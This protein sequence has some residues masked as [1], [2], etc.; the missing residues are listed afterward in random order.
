MLFRSYN[1][2]E[3]DILSPDGHCRA[4]DAEGRGTVFGSGVGAVI[5]KRLKDAIAD[6]DTIHAVI[7]GSA[8]NNDG[9]NKAGYTAPSFEGQAAAVSRAIDVS[10]VDPASIGFVE[11]HGTGTE[12]GDPIEVG[13]LT[14]AYRRHTDKK[15]YCALG[16]VKTNFGHLD[17]A[18]GVSSLVKA[19]LAVKHGQVPPTLH[20]KTPN[21][22][23]DF[24]NS[25]FFVNNRL[26]E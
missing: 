7:R 25:P 8:I 11:A 22:K 12:V 20:F 9:S 24:D 10:G 19:T 18:A 23:I 15:T 1:Y 5:L 4:F 2:A 16:S 3:G 21:P 13:A 26:I 17:R 6:G 14:E